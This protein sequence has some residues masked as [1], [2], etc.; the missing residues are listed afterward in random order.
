MVATYTHTHPLSLSL[1]LSLS[2]LSLS[3]FYA[4][5]FFNTA[6]D[7]TKWYFELHYTPTSSSKDHPPN[8]RIGTAN[9][10]A[11]QPYPGNVLK[12]SIISPNN[13]NIFN[14]KG[15]INGWIGPDKWIDR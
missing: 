10:I 15:L 1:S 2:S 4:N 12:L 14:I 3:S 5:I 9:Y 6:Q 7:F 13:L 8:L 11:F